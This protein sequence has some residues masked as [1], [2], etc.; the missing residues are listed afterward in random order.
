ME[1]YVSNELC[2]H[3]ILGQKWGIRRYQNS[4][5][6]LTAAGKKRYNAKSFQEMSRDDKKTYKTD[7]KIAKRLRTSKG[8]YA[9]ST[10]QAEHFKNMSSTKRLLTR[11]GAYPVYDAENKALARRFAGEVAYNSA[12]KIYNKKYGENVKFNPD[13]FVEGYTR[14]RRENA[15]NFIEKQKGDKLKSYGRMMAKRTG[16][17]AV[18]SAVT[19][20]IAGLIIV[21]N[22]IPNL[23][24]V[25]KYK[26]KE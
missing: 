18:A 23:A 3:G 17:A 8:N 2:H 26:I 9:F 24:V 12:K 25:S 22:P 7:R 4:D 15:K 5:G 21:P 19:F 14:T 20:P 1:Y 10:G 6:S 16:A 13:D 11:D